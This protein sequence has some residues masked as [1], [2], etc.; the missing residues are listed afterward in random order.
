MR[1]HTEWG[2]HTQRG[3]HR[4]AHTQLEDF[5]AHRHLG[6]IEERRWAPGQQQK[7]NY[8][9]S[10]LCHP[11][12]IEASLP[13]PFPTRLIWSPS[14]GCMNPA[15]PTFPRESSV[16]E[17]THP[18]GPRQL[19]SGEALWTSLFPAL[20]RHRWGS[21]TGIVNSDSLGF[22]LAQASPTLG[23]GIWLRVFT[24]LSDCDPAVQTSLS[25]GTTS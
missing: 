14:L 10:A 15:L 18:H 13:L 19:A 23:L 5:Q 1:T 25:P 9:S 11:M 6:E 16:L 24:Y 17:T 2:R 8:L 3:I 21:Q 12:L 7:P 20:P 4:Q 22:S